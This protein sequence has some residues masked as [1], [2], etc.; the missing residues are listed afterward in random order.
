[1]RE[2]HS[3]LFNQ[4]LFSV[5]CWV[6]TWNMFVNVVIIQIWQSCYSI[7][8][9]DQWLHTILCLTINLFNMVTIRQSTMYLPIW[10]TDSLIFR[11]NNG[12]SSR[13]FHRW[14]M[15][16][17]RYT[18]PRHSA[19]LNRLERHIWMAAGWRIIQR[20]S[21]GKSLISVTLW[22]KNQLHGRMKKVKLSN[23]C[24]SST[25]SIWNEMFLNPKN[26]SS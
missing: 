26:F 16:S 23:F 11:W 24:H 5:L 25:N 9:T 14:Q 21:S 13:S 18:W 6:V 19:V 3:V 2:T 17:R 4:P 8:S 7:L 1:M 15:A 10:K 12:S 20:T 22:K